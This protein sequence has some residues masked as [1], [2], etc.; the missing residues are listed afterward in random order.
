[1]NTRNHPLTNISNNNQINSVNLNLANRN[2]YHPQLQQQQQ[3]PQKQQQQ[4][5]TQQPLNFSIKPTATIHNNN[6]YP[7]QIQQRTMTIYDG[8]LNNYQQGAV[9]QAQCQQQ[10]VPPLNVQQ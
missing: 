6:N 4:R 1:M 2:R 9:L 8:L 5:P 7:S 3:Q 10:Q